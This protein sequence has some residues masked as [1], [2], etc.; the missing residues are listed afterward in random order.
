MASMVCE[1]INI[2]GAPVA[3]KTVAVRTSSGRKEYL[4]VPTKFLREEGG[5]HYLPVALI[6]RDRNKGAL[7]QLP[8]EADSGANRVWVPPETFQ[9]PAENVA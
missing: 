4:T 2:P 1:I 8:A 7:V 9:E 6:Q 5:Q 3:E